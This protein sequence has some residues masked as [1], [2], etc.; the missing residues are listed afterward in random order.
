MKKKNRESKRKRNVVNNMSSYFIEVNV[1]ILELTYQ[2]KWQILTI[3][4]HQFH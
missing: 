1:I 4:F 2:I 3:L